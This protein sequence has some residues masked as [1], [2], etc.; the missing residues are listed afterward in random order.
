MPHRHHTTEHPDCL[1]TLIAALEDHHDAHDPA[2]TIDYDTTRQVFETTI[3]TAFTTVDSADAFVDTV[4]GLTDEVLGR[5]AT[6]T[7]DEYANALSVEVTLAVAARAVTAHAGPPPSHPRRGAALA[8]ALIESEL[9]P[10]QTEVVAIEKGSDTQYEV[11]ESPQPDPATFWS[12]GVVTADEAREMAVEPFELDV[13]VEA[14]LEDADVDEDAIIA[15][16]EG[17]YADTESPDE[18]STDAEQCPACAST[19]TVGFSTGDRVCN[20]CN[21]NYEP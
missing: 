4:M 20:A 18:Q 19:N 11:V 12:D 9:T 15:E 17:E 8:A 3:T 1:Q 16:L 6:Y 10:G 14:Q 2:I 13:D 21:H 7:P 5:H